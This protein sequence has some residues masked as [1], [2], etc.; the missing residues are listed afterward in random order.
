LKLNKQKELKSKFLLLVHY[1]KNKLK[2]KTRVNIINGTGKVVA[3]PAV[4]L[5]QH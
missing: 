3:A 5:R 4:A 2:Q 1:L